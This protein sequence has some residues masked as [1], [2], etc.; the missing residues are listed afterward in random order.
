M[1]HVNSQNI[2]DI[3]PMSKE[4]LDLALAITDLTTDSQNHAIKILLDDL[5]QKFNQ[6][7]GNFNVEILRKSPIS[8]VANNF[9]RLLFPPENLGR[10]SIYTRY[11]DE[12]RLL[13]THTS[14]M[15]PESLDE[16]SK[17]KFDDKILVLPGL[18]YRRDVSDKTHSGCFH[19]V[20]VWRVTRNVKY[21]RKDLIK[22]VQTIFQ[23][24]MPG[25]EPKIYEAKH[26]Y[27]LDGIEVY[28][29]VDGKEI[30]ILE[31]GIAHPE[32]LKKSGIDTENYS[33]LALGMGLERILMVRKSIPD[34]RLIRSINPKIA[35]QMTNLE[36]YK[37]VSLM[38]GVTRDMS[39][40][41][42]QTYTE[43][44]VS[45]DIRIAIG[46]EI[47]LLEEVQILQEIAYSNLPDIAKDKL[48]IKN[49]QKNILVKITLRSLEKTLT[50]EYVNTLIDKIYKEVNKSGTKAYGNID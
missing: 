2:I 4:Q 46:D 29:V 23:V 10:S 44:D 26:P 30:E 39:Y 42:P 5:V 50:K 35:V 17:Q 34:I 48:G 38:P 41:V 18:V 45:D 27:T 14:A 8:N 6:I 12:K 37:P 28:A 16:L 15:I 19:Q 7:G 49:N 13:R 11:I 32:V 22:L 24:M 3:K 31:A 1:S 33:G 40:S 25:F 36:T 47:G 20:E 43:E 9:D 21:K